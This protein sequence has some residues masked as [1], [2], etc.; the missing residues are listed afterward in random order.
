MQAGTSEPR[1]DRLCK[2]LK[3]GGVLLIV[4]VVSLATIELVQ[5][6]KSGGAT[7]PLQ[8]SDT[9]PAE[10]IYLDAARVSAYL[11]QAEG[12][13][14]SSEKRTKEL[15]RSIQASLSA[16]TSAQIGGSQQSR[17]TTEATVSP[18]AA[19]LFY[20]FLALMRGRGEAL[21][22]RGSCNVPHPL[23]SDRW[24]GSVDA[25]LINTRDI[26]AELRCVGEGNFVRLYNAHLFLPVYA[27][28]LPTVRNASVFRGSF[29][30]PAVPF[31]APTLPRSLRHAVARYERNLGPNP[32]L[33]FVLSV[34]QGRRTV[35]FLVPMRL[36]GL[37]HEQS[38]LSGNVTVVGKIVDMNLGNPRA[39]V[40]QPTVTAFGHAVLN[41]DPALRRELG[42]CK[43]RSPGRR[44]RAKLRS[45][46]SG[47]RRRC[48]TEKRTIDEIAQSVTLKPPFVVLLPLAVYQ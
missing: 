5:L 4:F 7:E 47:G 22:G 19:D 3:A 8:R 40:D 37:T 12:G 38:L 16:G 20:T 13:L 26:A 15:A 9:P 17:L 41:A 10:Y 36:A 32:R 14:P 27:A 24:L 34:R 31:T 45:A 28:A 25:F 48:S 35:K 30:T 44:A 2:V 11:G 42:V 21:T 23:E 33:P 43:Y 1:G 18:T 46:R 29:R 39:Y 6:A